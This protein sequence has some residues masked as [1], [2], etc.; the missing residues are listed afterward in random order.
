M[1]KPHPGA[2]AKTQDS[3]IGLL[4]RER[5]LREAYRKRKSPGDWKKYANELSP[6]DLKK[7]KAKFSGKGGIKTFIKFLEPH[8]KMVKAE[9]RRRIVARDAV[10]A[11][12]NLDP[13]SEDAKRIV[14]RRMW[15]LV[16]S[17]IERRMHGLP[18]DGGT[19]PQR[20][21]VILGRKGMRA[22]FGNLFTALALARKSKKPLDRALEGINPKDL[23]SKEELCEAEKHVN[24]LLKLFKEEFRK[25]NLRLGKKGAGEHPA[26]SEA[27]GN[28]QIAIAYGRKFAGGK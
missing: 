15:A 26:F 25:E 7:L 18:G 14:G 19:K 23:P 12:A 11:I 13:G 8:V 5:L 28:I 10:R 2:N 16:K 21:A 4:R 3:T 17:E 6:E 24:A 27:Q 22:R 20:D 1:A 9:R